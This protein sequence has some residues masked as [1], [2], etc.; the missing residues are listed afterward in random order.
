MVQ[1]VR[2]PQTKER[3]TDRLH[4]HHRA[5]S[6]LY[7]RN[8]KSRIAIKSAVYDFVAPGSPATSTSTDELRGA[9]LGKRRG[10]A[11]QLRAASGLTIGQEAP[12]AGANNADEPDS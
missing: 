4:L 12:M 7:S 1:L 11:P 2:H 3:D 5:T 6:R 8:S 10:G 9:P